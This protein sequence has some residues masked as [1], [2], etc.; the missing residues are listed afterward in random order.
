ME[1]S[2]PVFFGE[3]LCTKQQNLVRDILKSRLKIYIYFLA[4]CCKTVYHLVIYD[5]Q[6]SMTT[7]EFK[8][9]VPTKRQSLKNTLNFYLLLFSEKNSKKNF[10]N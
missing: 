9:T 4:D 8:Q 5:Y 3:R 1:I 6:Q 7:T 10:K 2:P